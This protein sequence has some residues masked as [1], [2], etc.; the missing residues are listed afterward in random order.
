INDGMLWHRHFGHPLSKVLHHAQG[1]IKGIPKGIQITSND[2]TCPG[3]AMGKQTQKSFPNLSKCTKAPLDL[4][5]S[6]LLEFPTL[7]YH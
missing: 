1:N 5:V 3:C 7:S 6:D 2:H 4:S